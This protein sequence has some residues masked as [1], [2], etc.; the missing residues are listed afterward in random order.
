MRR[1]VDPAVCRKD[2]ELV[3]YPASTPLGERGHSFVTT[4]SCLS[5][6]TNLPVFH[7]T[8]WKAGSTWVQG[9]L[10]RLAGERFVPLKPDMSHVLKEPIRP[11]GVYTPVYMRREPFVA[12]VTVPHTRFFVM[13]DLRDTLVSWYFSLAVSH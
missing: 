13:R 8:H 5:Q 9:V 4:G 1:K 10:Q 7:V 3:M 6:N 2:S 12:A 11:G